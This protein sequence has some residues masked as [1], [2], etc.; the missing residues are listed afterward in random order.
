VQ[1]QDMSEKKR[2]LFDGDNV[3]G[4]VSI[5]EI[6]LE[7][8]EIEVPEFHFKRKIQDG[9]ISI[10]A[11]ELEYK[12]ARATTTAKFF[13]DWFFNDEEKDVVIVRTD[14]SGTE[15]AR[16]LLPQCECTK[17]AEPPFD[18]AS[19]TYAKVSVTIVPWNVTPID[20]E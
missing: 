10:P 13:R 19:P 1:S 7:K 17:Y 9:I 8:G 11:V 12:I 4:L 5:S 14:A 6:S 15:F 2:V 18:A 3:A 16:T 20:G